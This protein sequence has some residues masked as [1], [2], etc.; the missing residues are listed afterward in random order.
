MA[1][2]NP[3]FKAKGFESANA[4]QKQLL[5]FFLFCSFFCSFF[6]FLNYFF[7]FFLSHVMLLS[8]VTSLLPSQL[9]L[10]R[11]FSL[12]NKIVSNSTRFV[13][14][15]FSCMRFAISFSRSEVIV[16]VELLVS[17]FGIGVVYRILS[18]FEKIEVFEVKKLRYAFVFLQIPLTFHLFFKELSAIV[19]IYIGTLLII[20]ILSSKIIEFFR[21]NTIEKLHLVLIQRL[22]MHISTGQSPK[23]SVHIIFNELS[24]FEKRSFASL[25]AIFELS[26]VNLARKTSFETFFFEELA[27]I[28]NSKSH[29]IEQLS[30][31]RRLLSLQNNLRHRSRQVLIQNRAQAVMCALIY[32]FLFTISV[33]F[34]QLEAF[35]WVTLASLLLQLSGLFI[36]F[37]MGRKIQW[38][39]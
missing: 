20:L 30:K 15:F 18:L 24:A 3:W 19:L 2:K 7:R 4:L 38:V 9:L 8:F 25:N 13:N 26:N 14:T 21:Q 33:I 6:S 5:V 1:K 17:L 29:I 16:F 10:F 31:F 34:L 35:S 27:G 39:T 32:L 28:L 12:P 11:L 36:I 23:T 22:L 37:N